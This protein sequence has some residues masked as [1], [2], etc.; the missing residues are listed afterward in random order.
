[1]HGLVPLYDKALPS[2]L[3]YPHR[4]IMSIIVFSLLTER[5]PL[6]ATRLRPF[7]ASAETTRKHLSVAC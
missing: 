1:M 2:S 3:Q 5:I 7:I 4:L 6:V